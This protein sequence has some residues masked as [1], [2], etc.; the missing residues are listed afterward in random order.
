MNGKY[1]GD[2]QRASVVFPHS[3]IVEIFHLFR[4][5]HAPGCS[6]TPAPKPVCRQF[7]R[8]EGCPYPAHGFLCWGGED[9]CLRTRMEKIYERNS[10]NA[11]RSGA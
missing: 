9:D 10:K 8:C 6:P 5:S 11:D 1:Q 7:P 3:R 2:L 4:F